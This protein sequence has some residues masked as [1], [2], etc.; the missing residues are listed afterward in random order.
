M[1]AHQIAAWIKGCARLPRLRLPKPTLSMELSCWLLYILRACASRARASVPNAASSARSLQQHFAALFVLQ[2]HDSRMYLQCLH[3]GYAVRIGTGA[4]LWLPL[5]FPPHAHASGLAITY[6]RVLYC[7]LSAFRP[8]VRECRG[9]VDLLLQKLDRYLNIE[10]CCATT[11]IADELGMRNASYEYGT[12]IPFRAPSF[13][14]ANNDARPCGHRFA[15]LR[16][17]SRNSA[18]AAPHERRQESLVHLGLTDGSTAET[19][20]GCTARS[21]ESAAR[22]GDVALER[23]RG[24]RRRNE[25]GQAAGRRCGERDE[26]LSEIYLDV[27]HAGLEHVAGLLLREEQLREGGAVLGGDRLL[28]Q[29]RAAVDKTGCAE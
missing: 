10:H 27:W 8:I 16:F 1:L 3:A 14:R 21:H 2:R 26:R 4:G 22:S 7:T 18:V 9:L 13:Q 12:R 5:H 25:R 29:M 20:G 19:R 24:G 28:L 6:D 11:A 17:R 15:L 23:G